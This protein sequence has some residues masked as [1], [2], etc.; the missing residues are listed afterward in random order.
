MYASGT[1]LEKN[2][3]EAFS[4]IRRAAQKGLM[5]AQRELGEFYKKGIGTDQNLIE[6]FKWIKKAAE[7][8]DRRAYYL[9]SQAYFK[10]EGT[11]KNNELALSNAKKHLL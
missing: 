11:K 4:L 7:Q 3:N 10:G 2:E 1:H 8:Q 9:L 5:V 6:S